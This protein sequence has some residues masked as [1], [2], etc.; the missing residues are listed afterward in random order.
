MTGAAGEMTRGK[1]LV[2]RN[3]SEECKSAKECGV[4]ESVWT[5]KEAENTQK[6]ANQ[7]RQSPKGSFLP[8]T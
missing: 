8:L 3:Y 2:A 1:I 5:E 7:V 4:A 6:P